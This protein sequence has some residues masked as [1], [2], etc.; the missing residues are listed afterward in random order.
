MTARGPFAAVHEPPPRCLRPAHHRVGPSTGRTRSIATRSGRWMARSVPSP[1]DGENPQR[2]RDRPG[3]RWLTRRARGDSGRMTRGPTN[4]RPDL[5]SRHDPPLRARAKHVLHAS[6]HQSL[7]DNM[8]YTCLSQSSGRVAYQALVPPVHQ[9]LVLLGRHIPVPQVPRVLVLLV[10]HILVP[11]VRQFLVPQVRRSLVRLVRLMF[12]RPRRHDVALPARSDTARLEVR[13]PAPG[14]PQ[15]GPGD[16]ARSGVGRGRVIR[17][18]GLRARLVR[19]RH[20]AFLAAPPL[21][22]GRRPRLMRR[23]AAG[24]G[25]SYGSRSVSPGVDA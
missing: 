15:C 1:R 24:H 14:A 20:A 22:P 2:L 21:A 3:L 5:V 8:L 13:T 7:S 19:L 4:H 16:S 18:T 17:T 11:L 12:L 6:V 10:H 9:R 25:A 23:A